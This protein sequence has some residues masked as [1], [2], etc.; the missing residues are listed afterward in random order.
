MTT[1]RQ[2]R[3]RGFNVSLT[4]ASF[5][6]PAMTRGASIQAIQQ[7]AQD[8]RSVDEQHSTLMRDRNIRLIDRPGDAQRSKKG[9]SA[10][11]LAGMLASL[12]R[13]QIQSMAC[14]PGAENGAKPYKD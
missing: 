14:A 2:C 4:I 12:R 1:V 3:Q 5:L 9:L 6:N 10:T 11:L 8:N 7:A 13:C